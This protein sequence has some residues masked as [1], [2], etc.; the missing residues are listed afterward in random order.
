MR[1]QGCNR[2]LLVEQHADQ[3]RER[4]VIQ[5]RVGG[6][7]LDKLQS[8]HPHSLDPR[9]GHRVE[10]LHAAGRGWPTE[11][12]QFESDYAATIFEV[13]DTRRPGPGVPLLPALSAEFATALHRTVCPRLFVATAFV[14]GSA[15]RLGHLAVQGLTELALDLVLRA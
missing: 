7:I 13:A 12:A 5:Q 8:R 3:Q 6:R 15:R 10:G 2:L 1:L 14:I 4:V 11:L 9:P